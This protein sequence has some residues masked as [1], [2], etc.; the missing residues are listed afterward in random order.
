M[1]GGPPPRWAGQPPCSSFADPGLIGDAG[2]QLSSLATA[3]L[4][5]WATPITEWIESSGRG[6][7]P[8]W[9]AESLGVSL[10]AQAATLPI[11]LVS[12]G[13]LAILAPLV[14]LAVVPL[15]APAMAA[16]LVALAGGGLALAGAPAI[17]GAV[18]AAPGWAILRILDAIVLGAASVPFASLTLAPPFD[19]L[20]AIISIAALLA[21]TRWRRR[22]R[23]AV[24][25]PARDVAR[26]RG[27]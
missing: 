27:R 25:A 16:G 23:P 5:A 3:G 26:R 18:L 17:V 20:A 10:A 1:P 2:F 19:G 14:N 8:R 15:V 12:F 11:V 13:R 9:L 21:V 6:R 4:I 7:L 24:T 22:R